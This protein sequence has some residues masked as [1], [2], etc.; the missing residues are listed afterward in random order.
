MCLVGWSGRIWFAYC[1][2][3]MRRGWMGLNRN[4]MSSVFRA[5]KK[6]GSEFSR[7][8]GGGVVRKPLDCGQVEGGYLVEGVSHGSRSV[9][10]GMDEFVDY[11]AACT[12]TQLN[13]T[14]FCR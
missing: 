8:G 6:L 3:G 4:G 11:R 7:A 2:G 9:G 5:R 14:G 12:T 1:D 13:I 10:G